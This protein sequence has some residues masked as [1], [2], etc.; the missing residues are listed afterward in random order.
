MIFSS[1]NNA[2][3]FDKDLK[4]KEN[5]NINTNDINMFNKEDEFNYRKYNNLLEIKKEL[6]EERKNDN[7]SLGRNNAINNQNLFKFNSYK[8]MQSKLFSKNFD[9]ESEKNK[10]NKESIIQNKNIDDILKQIKTN[11]IST[12]YNYNNDNR[13]NNEEIETL[14]NKINILEKN[15]ENNKNQ[16]EKQINFY[17][18]QLSNYNTLITIISNFFQNISKKYIPNYNF[19]LPNYIMD[20]NNLQPIN[21]SDF[22]SKFIKIEEYISN[23]NSELNKDKKINLTIE[24]NFDI[25]E[26]NIDNNSNDLF[27]NKNNNNYI[28]YGEKD[29]LFKNEILAKK[30]R[31]KSSS[32]PRVHSLKNINQN[33]KNLFNQKNNKADKITKRNNSYRDKKKNDNLDI[34]QYTKKKKKSKICKDIKNIPI[35]LNKK[36]KSKNDNKKSKIITSK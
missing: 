35:K 16:Y 24:K 29:F 15:L 22:E 30:V 14:K 28:L 33:Q 7:I 19:N 20:P 27:T 36:T 17:T 2:L 4:I 31:S 23:L 25:E 10:I 5:I 6:N 11:N 9:Y 8:D 12:N 3:T 32:K 21:K 18:Q 34:I 26:N 1:H 13:K